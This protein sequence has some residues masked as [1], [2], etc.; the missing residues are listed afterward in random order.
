MVIRKAAVSDIDEIE[1]LYDEIHTAEESGEQI[2]G[3]IRD[4]Y[5]VRSTA[6]A[7]VKRD[8]LFVLEDADGICGAAIINKIQVDV[9]AQGKWEHDMNDDEICVLHTLAI[10]PNSRGKG[11]GRAFIEFYEDFAL[12]SGCCELRIDTNALN[13][14]ARAMYKKHG[15]KEIGIVPTDFN[16][17]PDINLV[18]L[19]KYLGR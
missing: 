3:W 2:T 1:M 11:Y 6:E 4:V 9:Y 13:A 12:K 7:A 17:I 16:G 19:E 10:S 18:L 15:Y 8:D 5:P 14:K